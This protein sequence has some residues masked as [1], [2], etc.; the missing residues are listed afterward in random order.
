[1]FT[2]KIGFKQEFIKIQWKN[3]KI[4]YQKNEGT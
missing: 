3:K 4:Q 1:M 2:L